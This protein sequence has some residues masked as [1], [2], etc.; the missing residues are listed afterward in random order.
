MQLSEDQDLFALYSGPHAMNQTQLGR[1]SRILI[2]K[3]RSESNDATHE[4]SSNS[5]GAHPAVLARCAQSLKSRDVCIQ[6]I[7]RPSTDYTDAQTDELVHLLMLR[8]VHRTTEIDKTDGTTLVGPIDFQQTL[9]YFEDSVKIIKQ[10]RAHAGV[11][12]DNQTLA[13]GEPNVA[14]SWLRDTFEEQFMK[15]QRIKDKTIKLVAEPQCFRG[16]PM[17]ALRNERRGAFKAWQK[18]LFGN[19]PLFQ[20]FLQTGMFDFQDIKQFISLIFKET[21]R[22]ISDGV[23]LADN[24]NVVTTAAAAELKA[25]QAFKRWEAKKARAN[26]R[27]ARWY[28][29]RSGRT[30]LNRS[31]QI[32]MDIC[33]QKNTAYG[34][35]FNVTKPT[36]SHD[37]II[38]RVA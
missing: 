14:L 17:K 12:K 1:N 13:S 4:C 25:K 28:A 7:C 22:D 24:N 38:H 6:E 11:T 19:T 31:E 3:F 9:N 18:D 23:H 10:A 5:G 16:R 27:W 2:L 15:N 26:L 37:A 35:G 36:S 29:K 21:T 30:D 20:V 32:L 33:M 34:H 8:P